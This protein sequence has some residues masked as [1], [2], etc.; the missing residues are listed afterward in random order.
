MKLSIKIDN[1]LISDKDIDTNGFV[2]GCMQ[3]LHEE[4]GL[5]LDKKTVKLEKDFYASKASMNFTEELPTT[6]IKI[7]NTHEIL[8]EQRTGLHR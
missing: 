3:A 7:D 2:L 5:Y 8:T 4:T 1:K 6:Q